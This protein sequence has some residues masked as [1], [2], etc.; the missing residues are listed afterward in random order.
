MEPYEFIVVK[1][2]VLVL[3]RQHGRGKGS[4]AELEEEV[5]HIWTVRDERALGYRVYTRQRDALAAVG[6]ERRRMPNRR[7]EE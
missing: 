6:I 4:K 1:D 2:Q 5:A 3:L 7:Q